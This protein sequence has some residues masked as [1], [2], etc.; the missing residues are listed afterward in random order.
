MPETMR[1]MK[2]QRAA[3]LAKRWV[4]NSILV[5]FVFISLSFEPSGAPIQTFDSDSTEQA[6]LRGGCSPWFA[7][8]ARAIRRPVTE[9]IRCDVLIVG[10]GITGSLMA[11]QLTRQGLDV[12][13]VDRELPGRGSTAARTAK[14]ALRPGPA[15]YKFVVVRRS[16]RA[17]ASICKR[18]RA[19]MSAARPALCNAL[20]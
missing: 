4:S 2:P 11:E 18:S 15:N 8:G 9:D 13:I 19:G 17:I 16:L 6:D 14:A 5:Q 10:C 3:A 1:P 20:P 7:G 12:V